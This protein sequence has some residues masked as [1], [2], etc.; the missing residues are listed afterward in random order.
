MM[1][2]TGPLFSN[3]DPTY[4]NEK[5]G[6][7]VGCPLKFW[8]VCVL[9]RADGTPSATGFILAQEEI[10][11]LPGF[12]EAFDVGA[13]QIKISDL[14]KRT[15]LS[16]GDLTAHDHFAEGGAPGTIEAPI[17]GLTESIRPIRSMSEIVV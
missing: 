5:M 2:I 15:G 8:K 10:Q 1:V 6:Y 9:I 12:E 4:R 7:S 17:G 3:S 16:F 13:A 14:E 11:Q